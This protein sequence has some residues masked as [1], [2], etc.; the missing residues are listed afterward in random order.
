MYLVWPIVQHCMSLTSRWLVMYWIKP[1]LLYYGAKT[2]VYDSFIN[3]ITMLMKHCML[4]QVDTSLSR[5]ES[6]YN[7]SH[8]LNKCQPYNDCK[9]GI[10][11]TCCCFV[12]LQMKKIM[13]TPCCLWVLCSAIKEL[14]HL[15][16][17]WC[18]INKILLVIHFVILL[19]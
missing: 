16:T 13:M 7:Q 6:F 17:G 19:S 8:W 11:Q 12:V 2:F 18:I 1:S 15:F 9:A 3:F 4:N 14:G 10:E 5:W